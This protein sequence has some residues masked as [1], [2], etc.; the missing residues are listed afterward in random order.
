MAEQN[1]RKTI[2]MGGFN[3]PLT[4]IPKMT[5]QNKQEERYTVLDFIRPEVLHLAM[6][7][8]NR[9]R[10][11]DKAKGDSGKECSIKYLEDKLREEFAEW[12]ARRKA[13]ELLDIGAVLM[14]LWYRRGEYDRA[15]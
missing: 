15:E 14:M 5:E 13:T 9:L 2:S 8:E 10:D 6:F 11:H 7:I 3:I 1:K 4:P 12:S